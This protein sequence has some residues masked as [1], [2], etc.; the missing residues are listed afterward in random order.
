MKMM[1]NHTKL[2]KMT[3]KDDCF[4]EASPQERISIIWELTQEIW[5]IK[6]R[7]NVKRR[8]QRDVTNLIRQSG[9]V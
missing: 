4:V 8:L 1:R 9:E 3:K 6:D 5:S 2:K 7:K